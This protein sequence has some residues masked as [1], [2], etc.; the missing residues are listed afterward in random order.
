MKSK[1]IKLN[2]GGVL[3]YSKSKLCNSTAALIGFR[4]GAFNEKK[5]GTAHLLEHT[6]FKKTKNRTNAEVEADRSKISFLNASTSMD[7]ILLKFFRTNKM[8]DKTLEFSSDVLLN[9]VI[10]DEFFDTEKG[11]SRFGFY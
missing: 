9:S 1:I 6:L 10:D 11:F 8:L 2:S 4:V 3:L 7:Y 5:M